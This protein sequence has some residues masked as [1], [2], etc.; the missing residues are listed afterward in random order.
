MFIRPKDAD[1]I[2]VKNPGNSK[3][4]SRALFDITAMPTTEVD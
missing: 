3:P 2:A 4:A 1:M